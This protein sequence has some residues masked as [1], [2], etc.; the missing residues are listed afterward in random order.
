MKTLRTS[1][2]SLIA[3]CSL[4]LA[5][6][7]AQTPPQTTPPQTPPAENKPAQNQAQAPAPASA[8]VAPAPRPGVYDILSANV[9]TSHLEAWE[10]SNTTLGADYY[11]CNGYAIRACET[12]AKYGY[13]DCKLV[14]WGGHTFLLI[15]GYY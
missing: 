11:D 12:V 5:V 14:P 9:H 8:P 15:E 6:A 2:A 7:R 10:Y 3:I 4:P 1:V 13:N